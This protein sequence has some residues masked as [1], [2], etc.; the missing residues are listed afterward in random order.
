MYIEAFALVKGKDAHLDRG[1]VTTFEERATDATTTH[2]QT[3]T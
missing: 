2:S 1:D 3:N